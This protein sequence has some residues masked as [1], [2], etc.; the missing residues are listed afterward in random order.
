MRT[1]CGR[2]PAVASSSDRKTIA[3]FDSG[4]SSNDTSPTPTPLTGVETCAS[5][6]S[7]PKLPTAELRCGRPEFHVMDSSDVTDEVSAVRQT[8]GPFEVPP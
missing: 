1:S 5:D 4:A 6:G 2:L 3:S 8:T 7:E